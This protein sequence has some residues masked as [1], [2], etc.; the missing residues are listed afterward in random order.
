MLEYINYLSVGMALGAY[1]LPENV[2][3]IGNK[4]VRETKTG[5][6]GVLI[7]HNVTGIYSLF[8]CGCLHSVNQEEAKQ[9]AT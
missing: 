6:S 9:L 5:A 8:S 1:R 3:I 4:A 2:T 7:K